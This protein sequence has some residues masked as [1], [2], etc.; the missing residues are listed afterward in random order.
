MVKMA[1]P[2]TRILYLICIVQGMQPP[3]SCTSQILGCRWLQGDWTDDTDQMLLILLGVVDNNGKVL[4]EDF[5][6]RMWNWTKEGYAELGDRGMSLLLTVWVV[7]PCYQVVWV[8][9]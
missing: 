6:K 5:A 2:A 4:K 9:E 8:S 7:C 3:S 1:R